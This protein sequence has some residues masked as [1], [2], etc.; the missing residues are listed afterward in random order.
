MGSPHGEDPEGEAAEAPVERYDALLD[1]GEAPDIASFCRAYP[2][3]PGL[4]DELMALVALRRELDALGAE[5]RHDEPTWP[6]AVAGFSL[7]E[8]VGEGGMGVVFRSRTPAGQACAVKLLRARDP[9]SMQ[10]FC[11][12]ATL[13]AQLSHPNLVQVLAH[14]V[15]QGCAYL[16]TEWAEGFSLRAM[17][18]ARSAKRRGRADEARLFGPGHETPA[19]P[20]DARV[21]ISIA[22]Q[23]AL[24][25]AHAHDAG[26]VHRDVKP[27]NVVVALSGSV[28]LVDFGIARGHQHQDA[29]LTHT[30]VFLGTQAYAPPEQRRGDWRA[31]GPWSDVFA[32]GVTFFEMLTGAPPGT[33]TSARAAGA[34]ISRRLDKLVARC[35][36][37]DPE[38]RYVDGHAL[39]S[40]LAEVTG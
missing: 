13:L 2:N 23:I 20:R 38:R 26:I 40:A 31:V 14:G 27:A 34:P 29:R 15:E 16:V 30:G 21:A 1:A 3:E 12:E 4:A 36:E 5:L 33:T 10:R 7:L 32:L 24:A 35:L 19:L 9:T 18:D 11:R 6:S 28:K 17:L 39:A 8:R 37:P 25:L 22:R